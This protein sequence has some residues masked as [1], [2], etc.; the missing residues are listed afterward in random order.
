[1]LGSTQTVDMEATGKNDFGRIFV[2]VMIPKPVCV[3]VCV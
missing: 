1:M 2:A 3:R